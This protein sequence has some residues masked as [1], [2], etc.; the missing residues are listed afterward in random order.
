HTVIEALER[1]VEKKLV[2]HQGDCNDVAFLSEVFEQHQIEGVIHFAAYKAVG[3]SVK[4]PLKYYYNNL[5]SLM[6]LLQQMEAS[7]TRNLVFSSSCTVYGQP[8]QLPVTEN[9]PI[10]LATSPYGNTKQVCE[11]IISD[12]IAAH[13]PI[14]A[15][16]L[17]YFNP[18]GA[19]T[20][21]LIGELPTGVPDNLV[22]YVTQTAAGIRQEL[23]IFG[24]DYETPDGT[25]IRDYIHVM[26]LAQAHVKA[27]QFLQARSVASFYDTV[28]IGTGAGKSVLEVVKAFMETTQVS[29]PYKVAERR[30]GDIEQIYANADK[31]KRLLGWEAKH[32]LEEALGDAWRWQQQLEMKKS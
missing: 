23:S 14:K 16:A 20:S 19:H 8:D 30:A 4:E 32:S 11:E 10:K 17:R 22:P 31:A 9:S 5:N 15:L 7:Q 3:E 21:A 28:N 2:F 26:D 24:D 18:I 12:C 29:L 13:M 27:L 6:A 1:I 25:C